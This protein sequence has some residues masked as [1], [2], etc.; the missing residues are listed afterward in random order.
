M[1]SNYISILNSYLTTNSFG[2]T[3]I[4]SSVDIAIMQSY[5]YVPREWNDDE[6]GRDY[7]SYNYTDTGLYVPVF[8]ILKEMYDEDKA[9]LYEYDLEEEYNYLYGEYLYDE[10][11]SNNYCSDYYNDVYCQA[12][13][14][15]ER[16]DDSDDQ[17][18]DDG[19]DDDDVETLDA[20]SIDVVEDVDTPKKQV[21]SIKEPEQGKFIYL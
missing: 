6:R 9:K 19:D 21:E 10:L 2:N 1:Y 8:K 3:P 18:D 13:S 20:T 5:S 16:V 17:E 15:T 14:D 4:L 7:I 11:Y 12:N